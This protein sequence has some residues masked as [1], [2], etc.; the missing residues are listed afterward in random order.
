MRL[1]LAEDEKSLSN[2]LVAIL[3]HN[4]FSVDA[5]YNGQDALDYLQSDVYDAVILDIMMPKVDGI[6]VLKTVR[7]R[8]NKIPVLML[9]AKNDIED[10][11]AGLDY[12][13]DDYLTKPFAVPELLARLRAIT[14]RKGEVADNSLVAGD[15]KLN[16]SSYELIGEKGSVLLTSKEFQIM[17]MFMSAPTRVISA[18]EFMDRIWGFDSEAEINVVWTYVSYLRKKLKSVGSTVT[19]K[20]VRNIGDVLENK[21]A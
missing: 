14:R 2:A 18:D 10:K 7:A 9:T 15:V 16:R 19:E 8:G 1:L 3:K 6:T 13:A 12:G 5:V 20:A 11:V 17:E 4:N 21:N